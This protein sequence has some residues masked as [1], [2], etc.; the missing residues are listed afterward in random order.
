V[1]P[2]GDG[3][4]GVAEW[5]GLGEAERGVSL[6]CGLCWLTGRRRAGL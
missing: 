2:T 3:S 4:G 5:A 1:W 6:V